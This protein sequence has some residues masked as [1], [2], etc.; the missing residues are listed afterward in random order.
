MR[1]YR[2][3]NY[4][5][6]VRVQLTKDTKRGIDYLKTNYGLKWESLVQNRFTSRSAER[7]T[8]FVIQTLTDN[9]FKCIEKNLR[10][11]FSTFGNVPV[12]YV[13]ISLFKSQV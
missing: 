10:L 12:A 11:I 9:M 7:C 1:I 3:S 13:C 5:S 4:V 2:F 6:H 8:E